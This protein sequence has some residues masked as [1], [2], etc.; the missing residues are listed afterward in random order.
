MATL[1]DVKTKVC[2]IL[3][4]EQRRWATDA[5]LTPK[6]NIAYEAVALKVMQYSPPVVEKMV[7][8]V[9]VPGGT[10]TLAVYMFGVTTAQAPGATPPL[11]GLMTPLD[12]QWKQSG[13]PETR[14]VYASEKQNLPWV[15]P[16]NYVPGFTLVW[17]WRG[18]NIFITPT[19]YAIDLMVRGEFAPGYLTNDSDQVGIHPM[20]SNW[21]AFETAALCGGTK[22][23][24]VMID[25]WTKAAEKSSE[26]IISTFVRKDQ[27]LPNRVGKITGGRRRGGYR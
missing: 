2:S 17:E 9:S 24:Q 20:V 27:S 14:Y 8:V 15:T 1:K 23:N 6:I 16:G 12:I 19:A 26:T 4:D 22:V 21:L 5:F 7:P 3:G 25:T 18:G 11:L 13:L 10:T